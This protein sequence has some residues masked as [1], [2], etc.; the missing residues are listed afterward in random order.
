MAKVRTTR[1]GFRAS[2]HGRRRLLRSVAAQ[3]LF[4]LIHRLIDAERGGS[5][6]GR[7]LLER[8]QEL[9]GQG[10]GAEENVHLRN[11]PV[12]IGVRGDVSTFVR[13]GSKVKKLG[14]TQ[15]SER[16]GPDAERARCALFQEND[17]PVL[18]PEGDQVAVIIKVKEAPAWALLDLAGQVGQLVVTVDVDLE[19][20]P[21]AS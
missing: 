10:P 17:L 19:R 20:L 1:F 2:H 9:L 21:A 14:Q 16:F 15:R 7:K 18:E 6:A 3:V 11:S 5:L 8:G 13:V 4:H 12:V